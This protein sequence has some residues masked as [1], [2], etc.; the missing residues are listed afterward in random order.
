MIAGVGIDIVEIGRIAILLEKQ[1]RFP[2][3]VLT[4]NEREV[5]EKLAGSRKVEYIAGRFAAKEAYSKAAG[6][7]IGADLS[8]LDIETG[9]APGGRP[10]ILKPLDEGVQL[11]IS[12]SKE[13]AVAQV[14]IEK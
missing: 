3:R 7:G 14:V 8:F 4:L 10:I 12:H 5:F 6:T 13:Y 2:V 9:T 1:P 11:S